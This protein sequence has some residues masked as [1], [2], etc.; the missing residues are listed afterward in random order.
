MT[1]SLTALGQYLIHTVLATFFAVGYMFFFHRLHAQ[2]V[3]RGGFWLH[4]RINALTVGVGL[5]IHVIAGMLM[6]G[7]TSWFYHNV[8]LFVL[9]TPF[10]FDG[11]SKLE[12]VFQLV[13]VTIMWEMHHAG[14]LAT[15]LGLVAAALSLALLVGLRAYPKKNVGKFRH[16]RIGVAFVGRRVLVDYSD[17]F[18][19]V[20]G[21]ARRPALGHGDVWLDGGSDVRLMGQ[22]LTRRCRARRTRPYC[23]LQWEAVF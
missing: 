13:C 11:F 20:D 10:F 21:D 22:S 9:L 12:T 5:G 1:F 17:T 3:A 16:R 14:E 2:V 19:D 18:D 15:P 23:Q 8:A 4:L 7:Q 6:L